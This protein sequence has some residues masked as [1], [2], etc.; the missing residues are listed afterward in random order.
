VP[1]R[2]L[3][4]VALAGVLLA[5]LVAC[6]IAYRSVIRIDHAAYGI[7]N[8]RDFPRS[9]RDLRAAESSLNPSIYRDQAIAVSLLHL[10]HPVAAERW[11]RGAAHEQPRSAAEWVALTRVQV[12][13]GRTAA[14]RVSWA[15]ARRL[16]PHLPAALPGA[17]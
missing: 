9:L 3:V 4:R 2:P 5:A 6:A 17:I 12:T 14:A 16:D 10:R 13:R 7:V 1:I 15:H 11:I 8:T